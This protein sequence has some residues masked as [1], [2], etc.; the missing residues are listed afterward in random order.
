M[1]SRLDAL[2]VTVKSIGDN[3]SGITSRSSEVADTAREARERSEANARTLVDVKAAVDQLHGNAIA[4]SDLDK[5]TDRVSAVESSTRTVEKKIETPGSTAAD[6]DV[7]IAVLA[8]ALK[9]T[10]ERG[11]PFTAELTAIKPLLSDA[12]IAAPLEPFAAGG[13]PSAAALS[14]EF[15]SLQPVLE[16]SAQ[17]AANNG[18]ILDRLQASVSRLVR[19]RPVSETPGADPASM[20]DRAEAKSLR[21]DIA[22]MVSELSNLPANVRAPAD[23]WIA[24]AKA[25]NA[26]L[27]AAQQISADALNA[28]AKPAH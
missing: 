10:V 13:V 21:G 16:A 14:A 22:G 5:V 24:R 20:L 26:A 23:G 15:M 28:L 11:A 19:V 12:N 27:A 2:E 25:R 17:P 18:S 3:A 6:R 1:K 7:R 8:S 4:K 9:G